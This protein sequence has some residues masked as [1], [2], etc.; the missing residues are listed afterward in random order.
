MAFCSD[1][2]LGL[3]VLTAELFIMLMSMALDPQIKGDR[4]L[5]DLLLFC[6]DLSFILIVIV[7]RYSVNVV[8]N[9]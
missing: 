8:H 1:F 5:I 3:E 2:A 6:F 9:L 4:F 7:C